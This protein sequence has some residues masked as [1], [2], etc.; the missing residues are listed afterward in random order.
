MVKNSMGNVI[1]LIGCRIVKSVQKI[2]VD[3]KKYFFFVWKM[4]CCLFKKY[5]G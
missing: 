5:D 3:V 1:K 4:M 2:K